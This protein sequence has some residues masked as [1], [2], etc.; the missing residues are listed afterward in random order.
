MGTNWRSPGPIFGKSP[1]IVPGGC[2]ARVH[3]TAA[4]S[5]GRATSAAKPTF[6]SR[7]DAGSDEGERLPAPRR[8][9]KDRKRDLA[10]ISRY[11]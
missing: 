8:V 5:W 3:I 11:G 2:S 9:L 4:L 1:G 6:P 10:R 7:T